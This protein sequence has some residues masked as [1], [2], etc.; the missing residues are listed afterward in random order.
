M[1]FD[2]IIYIRYIPLTVKYMRI[3]IC[4]KLLI[5]ALKLSIGI[6][7]SCFLFL[8]MDKKIHHIFCLLKNLKITMNLNRLYVF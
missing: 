3:I 6:F 7:Q 1:R 5:Q 4:Q 2:K 8:I